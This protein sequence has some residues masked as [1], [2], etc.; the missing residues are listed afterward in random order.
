MIGYNLERMGVCMGAGGG[1]H[2]KLG[3]QGKWGKRILDVD[4]QGG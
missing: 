4:G 2:F 3:I 1:I